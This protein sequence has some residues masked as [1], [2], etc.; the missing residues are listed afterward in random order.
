MTIPIPQHVL[1]WIED[2]RQVAYQKGWDDATAAMMEAAASKRGAITERPIAADPAAT[3]PPTRPAF[4]RV[5]LSR[6]FGAK[7]THR[8]RVLRA[9]RV[10]PGMRPREVVQ[11]LVKNGD[12]SPHQANAVE[13]AIKRMRKGPEAVLEYRGGGPYLFIKDN[14]TEDAA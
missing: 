13:T 3:A 2:L 6:P 12:A 1:E 8:I 14:V 7:L 9:L 4:A 10:H 11:Y 5:R